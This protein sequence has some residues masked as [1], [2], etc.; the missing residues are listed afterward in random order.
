[1]SQ[2]GPS[3]SLEL[4]SPGLGH[5]IMGSQSS[6]FSTSGRDELREVSCPIASFDL[7][8]RSLLP[9]PPF[10]PCPAIMCHTSHAGCCDDRFPPYSVWQDFCSS[11]CLV[12][13]YGQFVGVTVCNVPFCPVSPPPSW[14]QGTPFIFTVSVLLLSASLINHKLPV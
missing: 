4:C 9:W 6:L 3:C 5:V 12:K 14:R 1:M 2:R 11:S 13:R 7:G 10:F 8:K